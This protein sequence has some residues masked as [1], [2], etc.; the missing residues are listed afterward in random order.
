MIEYLGAL[1]LG[2]AIGAW[3]PT[4]WKLCVS[5][6]KPVELTSWLKEGFDYILKFSDGSAYRGDCTVWYDYE[7]ATRCSTPTERWLGNWWQAIKWG[8]HDDKQVNPSRVEP[9]L[10]LWWKDGGDYVLNFSDGSAYRGGCTVWYDYE[11]ATRC[12]TPT[13]RW[14]GNWEE[15][16]KWGRHDDKRV[17]PPPGAA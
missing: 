11:T 2:V 17:D 7:T 10:T 14:L 15:A 1:I 8:R 13:E 6:R 5:R 4:L 16:I 3:T 9:E 12:S